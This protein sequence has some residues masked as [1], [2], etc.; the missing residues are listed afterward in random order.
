MQSNW[1]KNMEET[2][3]ARL[4]IAY[5]NMFVYPCS[6]SRMDLISTFGLLSM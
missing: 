2:K 6:I 3:N 1:G 4:G 5:R